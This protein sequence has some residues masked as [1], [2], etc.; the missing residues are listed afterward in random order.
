MPPPSPVPMIIPRPTD[1][2][3]G[4]ALKKIPLY[5]AAVA[6][7]YTLPRR[8]ARVVEPLT[9]Y[10]LGIAVRPRESVKFP[11]S[12]LL[13]ALPPPL[14]IAPPSWYN[15]PPH[16]DSIKYQARRVGLYGGLTENRRL[17]R[18]YEDANPHVPTTRSY[19]TGGGYTRAQLLQDIRGIPEGFRSITMKHDGSDNQYQNMLAQRGRRWG[20]YRTPEQAA[21]VRQVE[22]DAQIAAVAAQRERYRA[23]VASNVESTR[24]GLVGGRTRAERQYLATATEGLSVRFGLREE[25][26]RNEPIRAPQVEQVPPSVYV[27]RVG[28]RLHADPVKPHTKHQIGAPRTNTFGAP[29]RPGASRGASG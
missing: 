5:G 13:F 1:D 19:R 27:R 15:L 11:K 26:D 2:E 7:L 4:A 8:S 3:Y 6:A 23:A 9:H 22:R 14:G 21:H 28:R 18:E 29:V 12:A 20:E 17:N 16:I 25:R 24:L 10:V